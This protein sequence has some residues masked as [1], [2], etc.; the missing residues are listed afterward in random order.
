LEAEK[1][2]NDFLN[3]VPA[4]VDAMR[5]RRIECRVYGKKKFHAKAYIT[6]LRVTVIGSVALVGSSNFTVP[7]LTQN[8]ELNIQIRVPGDVSQHPRRP[9]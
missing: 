9:H 8:I 5:D 2:P 4:I 6:H 3:G 1:E 7:G